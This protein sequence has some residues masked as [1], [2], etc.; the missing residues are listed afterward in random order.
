MK[1][2]LITLQQG[3]SRVGLSIACAAAVLLSACGGGG[4]PSTPAPTLSAAQQNYQSFVLANNGGQHYLHASIQFVT[5]STG[6]LSYGPQ[7]EFYTQDSSMPQSPASAGPQSM[8]TGTSS[9]VPGLSV[10]T[11]T[12]DRYLVN[13]A[14][15]VA[16]VPAKIQVSYNGSNVQETDYASDGQTVTQTLLGTSYTTVPLSGTIANSPSELFTGSAVGVLTDTINGT[17]LYSQQATWLVGSGYMKATRQFVGD[18]VF[19]GDCAA[20]TTTGTNITP[21]STSVSTLEAFFPFASTADNTTYNLSDGQIVTL[22]GV[23]AWVANTPLNTATTEYRVFY[24]NNGQIYGGAI[25]RDGTTLQLSTGTSTQNFYIFL[26]EAAVKSL[27][28]AVTF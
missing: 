28:A 15:V 16:A 9:V 20:P 26:N 5:S 19:T 13:G 4:S 11:A 21:C 25:A 18:T 3:S 1:N 17:S 7:T 27:A 8:T 2:P 22:A 24:Q 12:G 23:R 6:A 14:V 10:P